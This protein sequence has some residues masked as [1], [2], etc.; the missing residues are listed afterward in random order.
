MKNLG[1]VAA[2]SRL[3]LQMR[4]RVIVHARAV[5]VIMWLS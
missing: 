4:F 1:K 3:G 5:Q 2:V